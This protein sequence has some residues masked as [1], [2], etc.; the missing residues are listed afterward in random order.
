MSRM[1][2]FLRQTCVVERY[3]EENGKPKLNMFGEVQYLDPVVLKCRHEQSHKD[4]QTS[5]GS[6][7]RSTS[8]FYLDEAV[9]IKADY[10]INGD[11]VLSVISYVNAAGKV[12]GYEVLV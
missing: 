8:V 7:V 6:I 1:T 9:E 11:V 5:N 4:V 12:E 2:K 3:V 10:R